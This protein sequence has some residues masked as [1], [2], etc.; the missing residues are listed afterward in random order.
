MAQAGSSGD[1]HRE[2]RSGEGQR[3]LAEDG[4][5]EPGSGH[6]GGA[7]A[8]SCHGIM[9]RADEDGLPGCF[10]ST[11]SST[12]IRL[13]RQAMR[14][15]SRTIKN[16]YSAIFA[17]FAKMPF[18]G[19]RWFSA[20]IANF[21]LKCLFSVSFLASRLISS[22]ET[23]HRWASTCRGAWEPVWSKPCFRFAQ[24]ACSARRG[25]VVRASVAPGAP[26]ARGEKP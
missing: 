10:W 2:E 8:S 24:T 20:N 5:C 12:P 11:P 22:T 19:V 13:R 21:A 14:H 16:H 17:V 26:W 15:D 3:A 25:H 23:P 9:C 18:R 6:S 1:V 7:R 4:A